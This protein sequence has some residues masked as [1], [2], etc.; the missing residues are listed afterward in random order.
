VPGD[1]NNAFTHLQ[2]S[3]AICSHLHCTKGRIMPK[4][5]QHQA[6]DRTESVEN[7]DPTELEL[8]ELEEMSAPGFWEGV[9]IGVTI[10][11]AIVTAT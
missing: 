11:T 10:V 6:P 1:P 5:D 3:A 4:K 8:Q 7:I 9:T 2:P